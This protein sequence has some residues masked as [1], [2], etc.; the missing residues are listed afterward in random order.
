MDHKDRVRKALE[1][2][3]KKLLKKPRQKSNDKPEAIF[4]L[5]LK[6]HLES[7]GWSIDV[8]ESKGVYNQAAGRYGSGKTRAGFSDLAG[9]DPDGRAVWIETKAPGKRSTIRPAQH[10]F[11]TEKI[12]T[13]CFAI[14][15][16]SIQYLHHAYKGWKS[17]GKSFLI[18]ELP[19]LAK[20]YVSDDLNL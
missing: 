13:G 9:N 3:H 10:Q 4:M 20:R 2:H 1:T 15:C 8:V 18:K 11:L 14:V 17:E 5:E 16:D 6:K 7:L 19:P 12:N